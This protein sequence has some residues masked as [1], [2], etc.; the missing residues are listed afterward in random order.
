MTSSGYNVDT[1]EQL[2]ASV[3]NPSASVQILAVQTGRRIG[4]RRQR[5]TNRRESGIIDASS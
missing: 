3:M 4:W 2:R 5:S 1:T